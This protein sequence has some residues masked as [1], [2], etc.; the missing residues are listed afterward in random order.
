MQ[1]ER[2]TGSANEFLCMASPDM[3]HGLRQRTMQEK[4]FI[5]RIQDIW[6]CLTRGSTTNL[7]KLT[8]KFEMT[9][10]MT[11]RYNKISVWADQID[12]HTVSGVYLSCILSILSSII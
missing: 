1:K 6:R 2:R 7:S 8:R 10:L 5:R 9:S 3:L 11:L 4:E 12:Y